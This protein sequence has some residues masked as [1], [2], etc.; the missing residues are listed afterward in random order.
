MSWEDPVTMN[1]SSA[2]EA[3][4]QNGLTANTDLTQ[5]REGSPGSKT[6]EGRV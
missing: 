3:L 5:A 2:P 4:S 1:A 6:T